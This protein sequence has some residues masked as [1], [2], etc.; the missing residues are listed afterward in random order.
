MSRPGY[1]ATLISMKTRPAS[2]F[3]LLPAL[4]ACLPAISGAIPNSFLGNGFFGP[5][6]PAHPRFNAN[7]TAELLTAAHWQPGGHL[8]GPWVAVATAPGVEIRQMSAL[9]VL[10]GAVPDSVLA[11]GP[12]GRTR[13]VI[14]TF[15][16]AG[17]YFPYLAGGERSP[18]QREAGTERRADFD[19]LWHRAAQDLRQRLETACGPG[20]TVAVGRGDRLRTVYTEWR[21]EDF[22]LR[23]ARRDGHSVALHLSLAGEPAPGVLDDAVAALDG[24]TRAAAL[25]ARVSTNARGETVI[26]GIPVFDQ[27]FTPYCGVHALAM[28]A[29]YHGLRLPPGALAAGAGFANTGS[30]RG[31]QTLD[32][33]RAVAEELGYDCAISS[34]FDRRDIVRAIGA[35]LPVVVWRRVS[36]ERETAHAA[37]ARSLGRQPLLPLPLPGPREL[38]KL[39]ERTRQSAP[40]HASVVCGLDPERGTVVYLEPWGAEAGERRMALAEMEATVYAA[41][42]FRP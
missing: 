2:V 32:L 6:V 40:S 16:D 8:P 4:L 12:P 1:R 19:R 35:G 17:S 7:L 18:D 21:W 28:V 23:L 39:P 29:H 31:S 37:F 26:G 13:E 20:Q 33:H 38:A 3:R 9:P 41:F 25:S 24:P 36:L 10:F 27:G 42:T 22:R 11:W 14:V 15:V 5:I 34:R 30:A